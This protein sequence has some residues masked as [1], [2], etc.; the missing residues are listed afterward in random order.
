MYQTL[1]FQIEENICTITLNRPDRFNA[2]NE[3]MSKE[4]M[5]A[6]KLAEKDVEVRVII[7]T[8]A[9]KAFCSGQD[10][11]DISGQKRS[12]ADSIERRYN[13]M[14]RKV[15]GIEKP[16]ICRLN[17]V[18]AG[19]GASLAMACD[20]IIA[21]TDAALLQAFVNIGLVPD[22]GSS[23][24]LPR[25]VG[26]QKAFEIAALGDKINA[27]Q[28]FDLGLINYL[29][30]P[31]ELDAQVLLY[32]KRFAAAA[33]KAV[34]LIKRMLNRSFESTL[35]DM[36]EMEKYCQEIAGNSNDYREGVAAF[37]EKRK[38]LFTGN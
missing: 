4:F 28:A 9:G 16:I 29:V 32:S 10:L 24:F 34:G 36:L 17:G 5:D 27:Q 23:F 25:L 3:E 13:P 14:I 35:D 22:S 37:N 38:P 11:K 1:L 33:T 18:A 7:I 12:L 8:G 2:F 19:A 6:L 20:M 21:S 26:R 31:E 30:S 15:T